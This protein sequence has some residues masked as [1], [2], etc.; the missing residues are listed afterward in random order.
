M[1]AAL[2]LLG[3][4]NMFAQERIPQDSTAQ[5]P[6]PAVPENA[7]M[8]KNSGEP[9]LYYIRKI[10]VHG[11]KYLHPDVLKASAGLIEGD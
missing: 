10:N 4:T 11:I 5:E 1:A 7:P 9:K 2:L 3:C 8:F 6:R